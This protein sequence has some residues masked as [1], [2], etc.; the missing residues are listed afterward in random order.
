MKDH[1]KLEIGWTV[2]TALVVA[3][4]TAIS[5]NALFVIE[6]F[7]EDAM[8][9]KVESSQW[10]WQFRYPNNTAVL[11]EIVLPV[12][13]PIIFEVTSFDVIHSFNL[14][15]LGVKVD[16]VPGRRNYAWV[17]AEEP[18]EYFVQCT[19]FCGLGHARMHGTV[20]FK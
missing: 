1:T 13:E 4:L 7:P 8:T 16:A 14:P 6:D 9:I 3:V 11:D 17:I 10:Q 18:G 19:E 12:N 5:V 15:D 20:I 2:L